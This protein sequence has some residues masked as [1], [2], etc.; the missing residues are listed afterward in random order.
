MKIFKI[1]CSVIMI[2]I[3]LGIN[4]LVF[5]IYFP[6]ID[7]GNIHLKSVFN[8][9]VLN[10]ADL[11]YIHELP[12]NSDGNVYVFGLID[13]E[14]VDPEFGVLAHASQL[15]RIVEVFDGNK[16]INDHHKYES[17]LF[18]GTITIGKY[19]LGISHRGLMKYSTYPSSDN[20]NY[21]DIDF[22]N[23]AL[24]SGYSI[25]SIEISLDDL[26]DYKTKYTYY[27]RCITNSLNIDTPKDG[28]IRIYYIPKYPITNWAFIIGRMEE[29]TISVRSYS[30]L[31]GEGIANMM[32]VVFK[33]YFVVLVLLA[34]C[35]PFVCLFIGDLLIL[36]GL[37]KIDFIKNK[38]EYIT[39]G[40]VVLLSLLL[41]VII[42][43][44][45]IFII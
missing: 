29:N 4:I 23:A 38:F 16:W 20:D 34:L 32:F 18:Y 14:V 33:T 40:K 31:D 10:N 27:T 30:V 19:E 1:I 2:L 42:P 12:N 25:K 43:A 6:G 45:I 13:Y 17:E 36:F 44:I 28:D 26:Y 21:N 11:D 3:G 41:G 8:D 22:S 15:E 24:P 35:L 37:F 9:F 7:I 39:K 5:F